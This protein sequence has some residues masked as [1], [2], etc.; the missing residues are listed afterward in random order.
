MDQPEILAVGWPEVE[1]WLRRLARERRFDAV[2]GVTRCGLPL[3]A[4]LSALVPQASLAVLARNGPRGTKS[5]IYDFKANRAD[6]LEQLR[7]SFELVALPRHASRV[8]IL[9]DVATFG[10]TLLVAMEKVRAVSAKA[11]VKFACYAA[12]IERLR[13]AQPTIL[14]CLHFALAID[15][16]HTWV[17]FPWNLEPDAP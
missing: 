14:D 17:S 2:V 6:R 3:A 11:D 7:Q 12:D 9:D 13:A 8:L 5:A 1:I 15:N 16:A 4:A 10:D